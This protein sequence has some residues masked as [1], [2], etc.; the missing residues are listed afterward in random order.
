MMPLAIRVIL[1]DE[2]DDS[3]PG[4]LSKNQIYFDDSPHDD[5]GLLGYAPVVRD[6]RTMTIEKGDIYLY[7]RVL[8]APFITIRCGEK[9]LKAPLN[10]QA[11]NDFDGNTALNFGSSGGKL[12][13]LPAIESSKS[14]FAKAAH[15][16]SISGIDSWQPPNAAPRLPQK[17][18]PP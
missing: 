9:N 17:L 10:E 2:N 4:D 13:V 6:P 15:N 8:S 11:R 12:L 5:H 3:E 14:R 1:I 7:G 16:C 18:R